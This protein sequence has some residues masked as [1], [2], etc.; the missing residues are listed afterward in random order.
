[1]PT[2]NASYTY[3]TIKIHFKFQNSKHKPNIIQLLSF[4]TLQMHLWS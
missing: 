2:Q 3:S 4:H 1:M